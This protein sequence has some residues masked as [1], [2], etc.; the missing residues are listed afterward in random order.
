V[1]L[2]AGGGAVVYFGR[3]HA[4]SPPRPTKHFAAPLTPQDALGVANDLLGDGCE[5]TC[6]VP[7]PPDDKGR[8]HVACDCTDVDDGKSDVLID[9][10]TGEIV[11][12]NQQGGA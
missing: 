12:I 10:K 7:G 6:S 11:G 5:V 4:A 1:L 8:Y 9:A 3:H 2:G